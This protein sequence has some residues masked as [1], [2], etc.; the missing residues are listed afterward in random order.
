LQEQVVPKG[1][2]N[3]EWVAPYPDHV[4]RSDLFSVYAGYV[5]VPMALEQ[6]DA[7]LPQGEFPADFNILSVD[8][9]NYE[10]GFPE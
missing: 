1:K 2:E 7:A 3:V 5:P 4:R 9:G 10:I 6:L 8:I